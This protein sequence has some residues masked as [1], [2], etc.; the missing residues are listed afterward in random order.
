MGPKDK[1]YRMKV[2]IEYELEAANEEE[3]LDRLSEV[4]MKDLEEVSCIRDIAEVETE[5]IDKKL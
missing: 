5:I 1:V 2:Y 3:A 4:L